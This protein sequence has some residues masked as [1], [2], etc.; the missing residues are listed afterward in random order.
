MTKWKVSGEPIRKNNR[1]YPGKKA[2]SN[3]LDICEVVNWPT[4]RIR[5]FVLRKYSSMS[6]K[7]KNPMVA[8]VSGSIAGGIETIVIWPMELIKTNLQLGTMKA[9]YTGMFAGFRYHISK[10]G[11]GSLYRGLAPVLVGSIPK[12]GIRFGAFD[13]LKQQFA[14]ADG[15]TSIWG[16]LSAGMIAGAIEAALVT[17]PAETI[18]TKLIDSNAGMMHGIR[19]ILRQ[20]GIGGLY[21]GLTATIMKQVHRFIP[22]MYIAHQRSLYNMY[23]LLSIFI[24]G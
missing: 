5:K 8:V 4:V 9:H 3:M 20:E 15:Q 19:T 2:T 24:H 13:Y 21:Q 17:T 1:A 6:A 16:N 12:A 7:K 22:H 14:N 23:N 10:D 11:V 18:K